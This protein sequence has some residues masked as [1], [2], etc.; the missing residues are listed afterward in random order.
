MKSAE[1]EYKKAAANL[2]RVEEHL[3][4]VAKKS[5]PSDTVVLQSLIFSL[6]NLR[7]VE[8]EK[9]S[10]VEKL[11]KEISKRKSKIIQTTVKTKKAKLSK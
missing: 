6:Q 7:Q 2:E 9:K 10:A 8:K 1:T 11:Q 4:E 5:S 3:S